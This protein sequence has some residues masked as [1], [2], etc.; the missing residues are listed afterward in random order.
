MVSE[1]WGR[2]GTSPHLKKEKK[3]YTFN[4]L[5]SLIIPF[6]IFEFMGF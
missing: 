5:G 2:W 6:V 4:L 1:A 3:I